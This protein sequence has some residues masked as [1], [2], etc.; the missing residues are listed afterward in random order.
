MTI[1]Y[2]KKDS[3]YTPLM[4]K[5]TDSRILKVDS[6]V[7]TRDYYY[8]ASEQFNIDQFLDID[9]V[10]HRKYNR[11]GTTYLGRGL[12][13]M[14]WNSELYGIICFKSDVDINSV[15]DFKKELVVILR[16]DITN[17][18]TTDLKRLKTAMNA[19]GMSSRKQIKYMS[20][21]DIKSRFLSDPLQPAMMDYSDDVQKQLSKEFLLSEITEVETI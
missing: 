3:E 2:F 13:K 15:E 4:F 20:I 5:N 7:T 11:L 19:Y 12:L 16:S 21:M 18:F 8:S 10:Y 17:V 14:G 9:T 6:D 1:R